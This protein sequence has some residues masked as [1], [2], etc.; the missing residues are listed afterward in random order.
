METDKLPPIPT[1]ASQRW[2]E[3]RIQFLP[4]VLFF[5][6]LGCIVYLW[7][8]YVQPIGVIGFAETNQVNVASIKDGLISELFVERFQNVTTGQVI[9]VVVNTDP[10]LVQA[11]IEN[12]QAEIR[13][14]QA[15]TEEDK[16]RRDQSY[17]QF[18]QDLLT[19]RVSQA[20]DQ[21]NWILASN[22]L[23]RAQQEL[24]DGVGT[25]AQ[26]DAAV[27]ERD[28]L[29][30]SI[31]ARGSQLVDLKKTLDE[32]SL[33]QNSS[34]TNVSVYQDAIEKKTRELE[35]MLQ[36]TKLTA[37]ISGMV[38]MVHHVPGERIVRGTPIVSISDPETRRIIGYV[39]Q[40][41]SVVPTTNDTVVIT[42]RT[43]VR[44]SAQGQILRVGAQMEPINPALLALDSKRI[45]VGL[46]ILVNIPPG[47]H[48]LPGEY[49]NLSI[50][51][52]T[53]PR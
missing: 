50:E 4:F 25:A 43:Q 37:P 2:R 12:V 24:K 16:L 20:R 7:K 42:T 51:Y 3:F 47:I 23:V 26:L 39:R 40:P 52:H 1:P 9:A 53:P 41:V 48:L 49:V 38:S 44:Q 46:P 36:P 6:M 31:D 21:V 5:L 32:L 19:E 14:T 33:K 22:K 10:L 30:A 13:L 28:A 27:A 11:Q 15:R 45:E 18:R 35:L 17:Q 34:E 8:S 29:A